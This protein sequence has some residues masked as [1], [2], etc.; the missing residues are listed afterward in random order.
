MK[1]LVILYVL[2]TFIISA[3]AS[4]SVEADSLPWSPIYST[5]STHLTCQDVPLTSDLYL[6]R[7]TYD[8]PM[9]EVYEDR[10]PFIE[11]TDRL[12]EFGPGLVIIIRYHEGCV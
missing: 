4:P 10:I 9:V 7:F 12:V 5:S 8:W 2:I 3:V 6:V 11:P 1:T